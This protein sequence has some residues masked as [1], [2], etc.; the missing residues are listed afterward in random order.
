MCSPARD[1]TATAHEWGHAET[2]RGL[3]YKTVRKAIKDPRAAAFELATGRLKASPFDE[4]TV[5]EV[6]AQIAAT[7]PDPAAAMEVP[8]G[9]PFMLHLL[10]QSLEVLGDLDFEILE[11]GSES[12]AE[13]VPLGWD[14]PIARTPQVFPK[15]TTFRKLDQSDFDPS[16]LN[17][18]SAELNAEQLEAKFRDLERAGLML[19]GQL[20]A[21]SA[22]LHTPH[23]ARRLL[24]TEFEE[25]RHTPRKRS[26]VRVI[27]R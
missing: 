21:V 15:R 20:A 5:R 23:V 16:M 8:S 7:L 10:S 26:N 18:R 3:L 14:K 19:I 1:A 25:A 27:A 13:G 22:Y 24:Q 11:H 4:F 9:Q 12:Y 6:R 17:Y 2:I